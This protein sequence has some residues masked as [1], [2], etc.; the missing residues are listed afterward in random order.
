VPTRYR[1][2]LTAGLLIAAVSACG[3][4]STAPESAAANDQADDQA[5]APS[6]APAAA[7]TEGELLLASPPAG[8]VEAASMQTPALRM[9]EYG[10][11]DS[12]MPGG[13]LMGAAD[14][15]RVTFE[16][17]S[18]QPLPDPIDFVLGVSRDLA[19]RCDPFYD[20]N[21]SSGHENGYPT[22]VRLMICAEFS[23]S[24]QGQVV[25]TKAIQGN[26]LFYVITRR[27]LTAP[28]AE[29]APPLTAQEM[30][31]WTTYLK[32]IGV[33]DT[34]SSEH[35]CPAAGSVNVPAAIPPQ[36]DTAAQ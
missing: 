22:S 24:P 25:M 33:C 21:V 15:E 30:A 20:V 10:P 9:A 6:I 35:P 23:D 1:R 2:A 36:S 14:V 8:W 7:P 12:V 17:Q 11:R 4:Q 28:I 32:G 18:G 5:D 31:E 34:R 26:D 16:A 19:T 29:G 27:R 13:P 3:G